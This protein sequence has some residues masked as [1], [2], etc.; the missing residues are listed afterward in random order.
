MR[1]DQA[2]NTLTLPAGDRRS[3]AAKRLRAI[4]QTITAEL[5]IE[6]LTEA[7][8]ILVSRVAELTLIGEELSRQLVTGKPISIELMGRNT[9]R[10]QR[11]MT[12]LREQAAGVRF[13]ADVAR[14][15]ALAEI[16]DDD[17]EGDRFTRALSKSRDRSLGVS[18]DDDSEGVISP[19][20][21]SRS[22]ARVG[23]ET[24]IID[25]RR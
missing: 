3:G 5:H 18:E 11:A 17:E 9:D 23:V 6:R 15:R 13:R 22:R 8:R 24:A 19:S 16:E 12:E 21:K 14:R 1:S 20:S 2:G 25:P 4:E 10:L 7:V